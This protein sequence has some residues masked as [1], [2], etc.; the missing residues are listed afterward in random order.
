M[1]KK[2]FVEIT[3]TH[4]YKILIIRSQYIQISS[5]L[6]LFLM[7]LLF[8]FDFDFYCELTKNCLSNFRS[9]SSIITALYLGIVRHQDL[10]KNVFFTVIFFLCTK[11]NQKQFFRY[12]FD[13]ICFFFLFENMYA[14]KQNTFPFEYCCSFLI[15]SSSAP[16]VHPT[17]PCIYF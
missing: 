16:L 12:S 6:N 9:F 13:W 17:T 8:F 14:Y 2:E 1:K 5:M 4:F 7:I 11:N 3:N 15:F 10:V